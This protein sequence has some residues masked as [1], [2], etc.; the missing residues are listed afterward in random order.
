[1]P[2]IANSSALID[3]ADQDLG[4]YVDSQGN[5]KGFMGYHLI[6]QKNQN[7]SA[8]GP[9]ATI[10]R[11]DMTGSINT[12]PINPTVAIQTN[13]AAAQTASIDF[14]YAAQER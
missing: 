14:L 11:T 10:F 4:F 12:L 2:S 8:L 1:M 13:A 9:N 6:G 5:V 7:H 3:G